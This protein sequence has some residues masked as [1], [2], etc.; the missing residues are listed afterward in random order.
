M[1]ILHPEAISTSPADRHKLNFYGL[2][3]APEIVQVRARA[4][5]LL[6]DY[7]RRVPGSALAKAWLDDAAAECRGTIR[8]LL[9]P[10]LAGEPL[11]ELFAGTSRALEVALA[12]SGRPETI[13]L[14][15]FEHPS[16][17]AVA[18]WFARIAGA[19]VVELP[20]D[21]CMCED[22]RERTRRRLTSDIAR[23]ARGETT[24]IISDIHY[25]T[26]LAI[27]VEPML[28]AL[29]GV[30]RLRVIVDG[31]HAAGNDH[32]PAGASS[33]DAYVFSAHKWLLAPMPCGVVVAR[34]RETADDS[35]YD[36]WGITLP[37]TTA[38]VPMLA[39]FLGALRVIDDAG[40]EMLHAHSRGLR[41][42]FIERTRG[43]FAIVGETSGLEQTLMVAIRP[44]A[45]CWRFDAAGLARHLE[46]R[47]VHA[48]V[49]PMADGEPWVRV[50][51][52]PFLNRGHV[53]VLCNVF[54][55]AVQA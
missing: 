46:S 41:A 25:M 23:A 28:R 52:P 6:D 19:R 12:H 40:L 10:A 47:A 44:T 39:G 13:V 18:R 1:T 31:A 35:A 15:P 9:F 54:E 50:A 49:L 43:R 7:Q 3:V 2:A 36:A 16:T 34:A 32:L 11:I 33:C 14:S 17:V 4:D 29:A 53:D 37:R 42:H 24:L 45:S 21:P 8:R 5:A 22:F 48:L 26:G 30:P 55:N 27:P 51:F 38:N 20:F